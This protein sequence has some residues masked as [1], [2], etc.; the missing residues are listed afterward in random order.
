MALNASFDHQ[1]RHLCVD[2]HSYLAAIALP[3]Q[4]KIISVN[5]FVDSGR[6]LVL[7]KGTVVVFKTPIVKFLE[8]CLYTTHCAALAKYPGEFELSSGET[9]A[10]VPQRVPGTQRL[11]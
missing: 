1:T 4:M 3:F 5:R 11:L 2:D 8:Y 9:R 10:Q 6:H 7:A